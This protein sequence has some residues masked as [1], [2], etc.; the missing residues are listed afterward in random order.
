MYAV[1][2]NNIFLLFQVWFQNRRAK[3]R[4]REKAMGREAVPF[5]HPGEQSGLPDFAIPGH[6]GLPTV[7]N[8][9]FWPA[10]P[11]SPMF[12]PTLGLSWP[13]KSHVPNF[14]SFLSQYML[15]GSVPQMSILG[16]AV[17]EETSRSSSPDNNSHP[18]PQL[19]PAALEAFRLRTQEILLPPSSPRKLQANS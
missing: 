8:E 1:V 6:L 16:A 7:P 11:F 4:K 15:A 5:M 12:N 19:S 17:P 3:W 9:H 10:M 18:S 2:I 13:P 14:H